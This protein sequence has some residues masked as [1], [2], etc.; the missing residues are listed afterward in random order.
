MFAKI[1]VIANLAFL[2]L[3]GG[4]S[5][6]PK[7]SHQNVQN[8]V[9]LLVTFLLVLGPFYVGVSILKARNGAGVDI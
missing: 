6:L 7:F 2:D 9:H 4:P 5:W 3:F 1:F 8:V